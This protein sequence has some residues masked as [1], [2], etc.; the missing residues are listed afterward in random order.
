[1]TI[2]DIIQYQKEF[3]S[4][5]FSSFDWAE[6]I[7]DE[8]LETLS[9]LLISITGELGEVANIIKK[10]LRGDFSL[11]EKKAELSEEVADIF[12]YLLKISYQLN[13]DLE[14]SYL[15]KMRKNVERF[16]KY[17]RESK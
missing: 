1:M 11:S 7:S 17:E 10:V 5:H 3:D 14:Q 4:A 8:N 9:F 16:R 2:H 15:S 13:I 6:E 12:I